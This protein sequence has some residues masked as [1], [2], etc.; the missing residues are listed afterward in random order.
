MGE[1]A[2]ML[3]TATQADIARRAGAMCIAAEPHED[4][5]EWPCGKH[6]AEAARQLSIHP[7]AL[8][9]SPAA[10]G[11]PASA[12]A[13]FDGAAGPCAGTAARPGLAAPPSTNTTA[14]VSDTRAAEGA[15]AI[16]QK[17]V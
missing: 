17:Q 15:T 10:G 5:T 11:S 1:V 2:D 6:L 13:G 4:K 3:T 14:R 16:A 9:S 7:S 8:A 12:G